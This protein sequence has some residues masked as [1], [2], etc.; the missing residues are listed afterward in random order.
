MGTDI[1]VYL[2]YKLKCTEIMHFGGAHSHGKGNPRDDTLLEQVNPKI[3]GVFHLR[4]AV[5]S[6]RPRY[7]SSIVAY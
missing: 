5:L 6:C 3:R 4:D 2:A 7:M 1:N